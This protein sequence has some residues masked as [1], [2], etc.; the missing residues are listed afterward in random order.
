MLSSPHWAR[1][2]VEVG[3]LGPAEVY[4]VKWQTC[5][6]C[7]S[8]ERVKSDVVHLEHRGLKQAQRKVCC[9][10][11]VQHQEQRS[12][13]RSGRNSMQKTQWHPAVIDGDRHGDKSGGEFTYAG[14]KGNIHLIVVQC[15]TTEVVTVGEFFK[16][17]LIPE[18]LKDEGPHVLSRVSKLNLLEM[19]VGKVRPKMAQTLRSV[20]S[21]VE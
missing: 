13:S 14:S 8:L 9:L 5:K 7:R 12:Q 1:P 2:S 20:F 11:C 3:T 4:Q 19:G 21:H 6:S 17:S 15:C 18:I 10:Q 16:G